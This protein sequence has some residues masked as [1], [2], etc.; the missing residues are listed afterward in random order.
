MCSFSSSYSFVPF[1]FDYVIKETDLADDSRQWWL[2]AADGGKQW[3]LAMVGGS[4]PW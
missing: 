3:R 2:A 4:K 1:L